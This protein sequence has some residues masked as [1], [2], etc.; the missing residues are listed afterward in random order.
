MKQIT[1]LFLAILLWSCD[2]MR[3]IQ[4]QNL[5]SNQ[6]SITWTIREDS[7][8]SNRLYMSNSREVVFP[9]APS[10]RPINLSSGV[11]S[12]SPQALYQFADDLESLVIEWGGRQIRIT[13]TDS[14]ARFLLHR[15]R[16]LDKSKIR[17][18]IKD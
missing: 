8:H 14:I 13:G 12:W 1:V 10:S 16:G 9:L 3:R 4:M 2:P 15:R 18:T 7:I 6:A 17:I 11:G 5:S